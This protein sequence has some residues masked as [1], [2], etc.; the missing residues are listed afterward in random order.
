MRSVNIADLKN[1]LSHY[2]HEVRQG[3]ELLIRDR[4]TPV[5]KIV[6]LS[7]TETEAHELALAA[8]G[9]LKLPKSRPPAR[10]WSTPAPKVDFD[11]LVRAV[12]SERDDSR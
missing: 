8:A 3:A 2:L 6:P 11:Q 10:F 5:A 9:L 1:N 4:N 12:S 7:V